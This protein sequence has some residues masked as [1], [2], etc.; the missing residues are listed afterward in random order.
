MLLEDSNDMG[1]FLKSDNGKVII[2]DA[3]AKNMA[4]LSNSILRKNEIIEQLL[5]G[6][7]ENPNLPIEFE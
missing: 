6:K 4:S 3:H 1:A 2:R 7:I 5:L